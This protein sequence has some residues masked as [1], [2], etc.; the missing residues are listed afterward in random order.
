MK[1]FVEWFKKMACKYTILLSL[2]A[3]FSYG[4]V[5]LTHPSFLHPKAAGI[6]EKIVKD[7][8]KSKASRH[9]YTEIEE[10][11]VFIKDM[12]SYTTSNMAAIDSFGIENIIGKKADF[13]YSEN[14]LLQINILYC[15]SVD[16]KIVKSAKDYIFE[17]FLSVF[18]AI[19]S[20]WGA[21]YGLKVD[22]LKINPSKPPR[23]LDKLRFS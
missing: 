18:V 10:Y 19:F 6:V 4:L 9:S 17:F 7:T 20:T 11:R 3:L 15:L 14:E 1:L 13:R 2:T 22:Y 12:G 8:Y 23:K 16:G 5:Y 21:L